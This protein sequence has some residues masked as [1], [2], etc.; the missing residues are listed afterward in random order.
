[1][2]EEGVLEEAEFYSLPDLAK[3]VKE[4]IKLRDQPATTCS[5]VN[6]VYRVLQCQ[7]GE[8]S[9]ML[10]TFTD[11]WKCEQVQDARR[12]LFFSV[13]VALKFFLL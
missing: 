2:A 7:E 11:G 3:A 6:H 8:L 9:Q 10:S 12:S 13:W 1:M 5:N 4:K